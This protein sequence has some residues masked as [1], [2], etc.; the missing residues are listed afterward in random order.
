MKRRFLFLFTLGFITSHGGLSGVESA[1]A[2]QV[3]QAQE[4]TIRVSNVSELENAFDIASHNGQD[5]VI[6]IQAGTYTITKTLVYDLTYRRSECGRKLTIRAEGA[7]T[8]K[9]SR[10]IRILFVNTYPCRS[11]KSG[12]ITIQGITFQ[13]GKE[14]QGGAVAVSTKEAS[15]RFINNSF[16]NNESSDGGGVYV[17]TSSGSVDFENNVFTDNKSRNGGGVYVSAERGIIR[18]KNNVFNSNT[19]EIGGGVYVYNKQVNNLVFVNNT[20]TRN[21]ATN[22]GG[23]VYVYVKEYSVFKPVEFYNNIF[24]NNTSKN[25]GYE[26]YVDNEKAYE[27][28]VKIAHNLFTPS[29]PPID[30]SKPQ[31]ANVY[32]DT[33]RNYNINL[34]TGCSAS[35]SFGNIQADPMFVDLQNGNL[36]LRAGSP[37]INKG[38]NKA[39]SIPDTDK[40]GNQRIWDGTV[41][42]GAYEYG[43]QP[44]QPQPKPQS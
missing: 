21:N 26:V 20:F 3:S 36:R 18:F 1:K 41:D 13:N 12:D 38:C 14:N 43:S 2:T 33:V 34:P 37:A 31:S 24:W 10:A 17:F 19:A 7:A 8:I 29:T 42:M 25:D 16:K 32:I 11:D 4:C 5:D 40:D 15:I 6:C 23:G 35:G 22:I 39:S 28:S 9:A 30:F 44:P 27:L